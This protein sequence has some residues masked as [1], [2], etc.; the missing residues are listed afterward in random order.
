VRTAHSHVIHSYVCA[1]PRVQLFAIAG[2]GWPHC[3]TVSLAHANQ[4]LLPEI[5]KALLVVS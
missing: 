4:L 3:A 5:V 1:A 2:N